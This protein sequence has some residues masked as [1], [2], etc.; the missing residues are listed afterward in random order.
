MN[1]WSLPF[2]Y[3]VGV[4]LLAALAGFFYYAREAVQPLVLSAFIAYLF[5]PAA[6]AL[7][8][9]TRLSRRAAVTIVYFS[10]IVLL[11][12]IPATVAPLFLD[13]LTGVG[14]DLFNLLHD[15]QQALAEPLVFMGMSLDLSEVGQALGGLQSLLIT[16]L[17]E[18][19]FWILEST[20]RGTVW[21]LVIIVSVYLF[22]TYWPE[23]RDWL[24]GLAP[25]QARPEVEG[26]YRQVRGVWIAYLRGQILLMFIVGV[27]F[28]IA[29]Y[30]LGIPGAFV[31]GVI[32]GLF[33]L[34][35]DLGPVVAVALA[36]GVA[37]L[38][39]SSWIPLSNAWV[40]VIVFLAYFVLIN[41]KNIWLRPV[42]M[43][44]S[45]HM[46]EVVVFVSILVATILN[47]ILGALLVVPVLASVIVIFNYLLR[48]VL[49]RQTIEKESAF[50]GRIRRAE[51]ALSTRPARR[52][53]KKQN[54]N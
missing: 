45:V 5:N 11:F 22:L 36:M 27:V 37:L 9:K 34:V 21:L 25:E 41:L 3:L 15:F 54:R 17:P 18:D 42:I 10:V 23:M 50:V 39:G 40:T 28:T 12:A 7:A 1:Q 53:I 6:V 52:I 20:S 2:R 33:T 26:L 43:G 8:E 44:R 49:G 29:W 31:L 19:A 4:F 24:I 30:I 14:R 16:P 38:E 46:N 35:P 48:K 13:E 51:Q 32:A 47:G